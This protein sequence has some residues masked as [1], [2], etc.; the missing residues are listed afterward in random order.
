MVKHP[1]NRLGGKSRL[2]KQII[3]LIPKHK[4]YVEPFFGG[5]VIY[6]NK[7]PAE[8][9]VINDIDKSVI[10][11]LMLLTKASIDVDDYDFSVV[12]TLGKANEFVRT[13]PDCYNQQLLK[14]LT[15][16]RGT[17]GNMGGKRNI[18]RL[19]DNRDTL[20]NMVEYKERLAKTEVYNQSYLDLLDKY[21]GDDTF[22]YFDPPYENS[23][24]M[25]DYP[26]MDY[27]TLATKLCELRGK[28]LL[29]INDSPL[30]RDLFAGYN[31][32]EVL[33]RGMNSRDIG[34]CD[35]VELLIYNF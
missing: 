17:F 35:R 22:F 31:V 10:D 13:E 4:T 1:F 34:C 5:G 12:E 16:S 14:A 28:W 11:G 18:I 6:W 8:L 2:K 30:I 3:S 7:E 15:I 19:P 26:K 20:S 21:D 24:G 33:L 32:R 29:S 25:Y 23:D 27:G 9:S